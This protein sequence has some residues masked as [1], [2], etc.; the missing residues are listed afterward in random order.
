MYPFTYQRVTEVEAAV[1]A[2][3]EPNAKLLAG[4]MSLLPAMKHRLAAHD[5]L[6]DLA[7][8][9]GLDGISLVPGGLRI[10]AMARH[11]A[12]ASSPVVREALPALAQLAGGI[13]DV[14]VRY[15]GTAGGSIAN[16][17][18]A[19][20]YPAAVLGLGASV[21]TDRRV[22]A[23]DTFFRSLFET[24][25]EPDE[26]IVA[27]E[28]PLPS[29]AIYLKFANLA[30]RYALV[31]LFLARFGAR[32]RVA[33]TGAAGWVFRHTEAEEA[34]TRRFSPASLDPL[35]PPDVDLIS[36]VHAPAD[37][38]A[39]LI[40]VLLGRAVET[41]NTQAETPARPATGD[42]A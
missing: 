40:R 42:S 25:L 14:Q 31:G 26:I 28:F 38:R 32:V 17:D 29:Q 4:G 12:V 8:V 15:R 24:A 22:I 37:Y 20:D 27:V 13:G 19:A 7:H 3:R 30:S 5:R 9:A 23:A 35:G 2:L 39:H 16:A 1:A 36:D 10:G 21:V 34:L 18:P 41:L 33:V 11:H 6:I